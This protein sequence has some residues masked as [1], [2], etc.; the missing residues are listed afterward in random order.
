METVHDE[1][2]I[3]QLRKCLDNEYVVV[4]L[5]EIDLRSDLK[6]KKTIAIIG[7]RN[8]L[9]NKLISLVLVLWDAQLP[10]ESTRKLDNNI[11]IKHQ[12]IFT[13]SDMLISFISLSIYTV[14]TIVSLNLD[15]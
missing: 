4:D 2:H 5:L 11:R 13:L 14:Y 1:F 7:Q 9:L 10:R 15:F 12:Y 3:S 8:K 6:Y